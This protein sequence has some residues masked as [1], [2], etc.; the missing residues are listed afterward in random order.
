MERLRSSFR[1]GHRNHG[2]YGGA[3]YTINPGAGNKN[4]VFLGWELQYDFSQVFTFGGEIYFQSADATDSKSTVAFNA[5]GSVNFSSKMHFIFSL[6]HSLM[7]E[8]F[9]SSYAGLL[10]TI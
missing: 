3:G 4:P 1:C 7:N 10:W 5:G 2:T 6:G 8:N 9:F